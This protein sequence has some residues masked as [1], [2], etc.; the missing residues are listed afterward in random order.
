M[1]S[2]A[3]GGPSYAGVQWVDVSQALEAFQVDYQDGEGEVILSPNGL[4]VFVL[5]VR[6]SFVA[7]GD[8]YTTETTEPWSEAK[9]RLQAFAY[10]S[11]IDTIKEVDRMIARVA[12]GHPV[13]H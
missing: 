6:L 3:R 12:A 7:G 4:G 5:T 11:V 1:A 8:A 10:R 2:R 13:D 9:G